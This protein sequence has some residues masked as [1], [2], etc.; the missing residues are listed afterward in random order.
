MTSS[1]IALC[2]VVL[3]GGAVVAWVAQR[4]FRTQ[5]HA[6]MLHTSRKQAHQWAELLQGMRSGRGRIAQVE[7]V[8]QRAML[9][10]KVILYW[11]DTGRRQDG[12]LE[13]LDVHAGQWLLLRGSDGFGRHHGTRVRY[14]QP[15]DVLARADAA[16][17]GSFRF[18][19]HT[20]EPADRVL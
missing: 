8:Y 11:Y 16:A 2:A 1:L 10:T 15:R 9:G 6:K 19:Q 13:E 5:Q 20:S 4:R 7:Q 14:V 12:W 17:P 3:A 18:I